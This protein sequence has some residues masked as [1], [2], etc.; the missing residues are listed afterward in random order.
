MSRND[1]VV[2]QEGK[3]LAPDRSGRMLHH[4]TSGP[5]VS[6]KTVGVIP[7]EH[8]LVHEA[9][10]QASL[11]PGVRSLEFV[12]TASVGT[13]TVALDAVVVVRE[14]GRFCLDVVEARANRGPEEDMLFSRVL[15]DLGLPTLTMSAVDIRR[16]PLYSN[17]SSVWANRLRRVDV[18]TRLAVLALLQDDGPM[19]L[20]SLLQG[21][22]CDRDPAPAVMAMA[23]GGLIGLDLASA[24]L[25]PSTMVTS[26]S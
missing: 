4:T 6:A 1:F 16:E 20:G 11:D 18:G 15:S 13:D 8:P 10:V 14:D 9:L 23:C 3:H 21:L 2:I 5:F 22:R 19:R 17:A 24:T 26:L 12:S 7:T 25:G